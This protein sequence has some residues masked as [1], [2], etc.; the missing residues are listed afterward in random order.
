MIFEK[1]KQDFV[2]RDRVQVQQRKVVY[3]SS[4]VFGPFLKKRVSQLRD[5]LPP[6]TALTF[7]K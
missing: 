3:Y 7:V 4:N 2:F 5:L 6:K 1:Q